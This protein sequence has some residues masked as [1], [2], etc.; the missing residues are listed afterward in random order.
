MTAANPPPPT[1][2]YSTSGVGGRS[3]VT[4]LEAAEAADVPLSFVAV[5]VN[6]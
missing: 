6:V 1:T 2:R 3:G 5:T 4:E